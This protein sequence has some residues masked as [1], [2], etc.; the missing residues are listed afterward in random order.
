M[1]ITL[2]KLKRLIPDSVDFYW[3]WF[4]HW[5]YKREFFETGFAAQYYGF[6]HGITWVLPI[7]EIG[8]YWDAP[9]CDD[10]IKD[11]KN[12]PESGIK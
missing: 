7:C 8:F 3:E 12:Y 10:L 6:S 4:W 5:P 9:N 11:L 2:R 1:E